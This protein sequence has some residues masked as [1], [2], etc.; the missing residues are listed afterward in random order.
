MRTFKINYEKLDSNTVQTSIDHL[1]TSL[2]LKTF[3]MDNK[4]VFNEV[5]RRSPRFKAMNASIHYDKKH[6]EYKDILKMLM[7]WKNLK[8]KE[9]E[10]KVS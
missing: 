4:I 9:Y 3:L 5:Q 2:K 10:N 8:Q 6:M 1:K 7:A